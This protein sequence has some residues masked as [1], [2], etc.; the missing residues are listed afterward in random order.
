MPVL[1]VTRCGT[2]DAFTSHARGNFLHYAGGRVAG[3]YEIG[4][5]GSI[6]GVFLKEPGVGVFVGDTR[7]RVFFYR[8]QG[9]GAYG[10]E[11]E[12]GGGNR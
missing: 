4:Y 10:E 8:C 2:R 7:G 6:P 3:R 9:D 12:E 11:M 5:E 1:N